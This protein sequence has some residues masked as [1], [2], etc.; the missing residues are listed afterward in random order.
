MAWA[1]WIALGLR[2]YF[3]IYPSSRPNTDTMHNGLWIQSRQNKY[4]KKTISKF[5]ALH[6][7]NQ[8]NMSHFILICSVPTFKQLLSWHCDLPKTNPAA[9]HQVVLKLVPQ[10][11]NISLFFK[12][13]VIVIEISFLFSFI[14]CRFTFKK[15]CLKFDL[16]QL[17]ILDFLD[18]FLNAILTYHLS[19][20]FNISQVSRCRFFI[21]C[22]L[23]VLAR[24]STL[25]SRMYLLPSMSPSFQQKHFFMMFIVCGREPTEGSAVII[26]LYGVPW[27]LRQ[28]NKKVHICPMRGDYCFCWHTWGTLS[29]ERG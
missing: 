24:K 11:F 8:S 1:L 17:V 15:G 13:C 9:S 22:I 7:S 6:Y 4:I 25:L 3:T 28:R 29:P 26:N 21:F 12:L 16:I 14:N 18:N 27:G 20:I 19:C 5:K 10:F 2:P 23:V